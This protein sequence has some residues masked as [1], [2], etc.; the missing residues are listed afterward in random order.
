MISRM[1]ALVQPVRHLSAS[2]PGPEPAP[3][4]EASD[5]Y[6]PAE[7]SRSFWRL[8]AALLAG[9]V[10]L[11]GL[12]GCQPVGFDTACSHRDAFVETNPEYT[13]RL[14]HAKERLHELNSSPVTVEGFLNRHVS[15]TH[16]GQG[17]VVVSRGLLKVV[18]DDELLFIL[19]HE[20]GHFRLGHLKDVDPRELAPPERQTLLHGMEKEAD[21]EGVKTLEKAGLPRSVAKTA[22]TKI[23]AYTPHGQAESETHPSLQDRF[24]N[25]DHCPVNLTQGLD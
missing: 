25:I 15:A 23:V 5:H 8:P 10:A 22:L 2:P 24:D 21:C 16:C 11:A 12:A 14:A 18:N 19:G 1:S 13:G 3:A 9:G 6:A 7:P 17:R 20:D 4:P